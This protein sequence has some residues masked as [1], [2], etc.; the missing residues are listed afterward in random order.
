MLTKKL[1]LNLRRAL[2]A[3]AAVML[4]AAPTA[5]GADNPA[6]PG[7]SPEFSEREIQEFSNLCQEA[8]HD[9]IVLSQQYYGSEYCE[10]YI[11]ACRF[12]EDGN[13]TGGKAAG[14][15]PT[16]GTYNQNANSYRFGNLFRGKDCHAR[17]HLRGDENTWDICAKVIPTCEGGQVPMLNGEVTENP[18]APCAHRTDPSVNLQNRAGRTKLHLAILEG[19]YNEIDELLALGADPNIQDR[20]GETALHYAATT[21]TNAKVVTSRLLEG[22]A[23]PSIQS[24]R[25]QTALH[26][27][28]AVSAA[29]VRVLLDAGADPQVRDR[30]GQTPL[31][32]AEARGQ[33]QAA[34]LLIEATR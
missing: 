5:S 26:V 9:A 21:G 17:N 7:P 10:P 34:T 14:C 18:F 33:E 12:S 19:R 25:G 24:R 32:V 2:S 3:L 6:F 8:G 27:A 11:R 16:Y 4:I 22:G 30:R 15:M 1:N 13:P 29:A 31:Q 28:A 23:D 20:R